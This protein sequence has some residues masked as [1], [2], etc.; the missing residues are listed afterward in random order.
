MAKEILT[1]D[2][3]KSL[4]TYAPLTGRFSSRANSRNR[5]VGYRSQYGYLMV[6]IN[7]KQYRAH[8]LAWLYVY[9]VWPNDEVDHINGNKEDNR[10]GIYVTCRSL[11]INKT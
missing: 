9:G 2:R 10:I 8:R 5:A 1:A 3:L 6:S 7:R 11:L 4:F